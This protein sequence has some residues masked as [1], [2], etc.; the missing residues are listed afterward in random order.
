MISVQGQIMKTV[1]LKISKQCTVVL[2]IM[3][4]HALVDNCPG[5]YTPITNLNTFKC[6]FI[7]GISG[8]DVRK[9]LLD[10][11]GGRMECD[12]D[13]AKNTLL[14]WGTQSDHQAIEK[15][16]QQMQ[17]LAPQKAIDG[18]NRS[19]RII[20]AFYLQQAEQ[21]KNR[22]IQQTSGRIQAP[23]PLP[24]SSQGRNQNQG[25]VL[26]VANNQP[27]Q[28]RSV[29]LRNISATDFERKLIENLGKRF[30][31][32]TPLSSNTETVQYQLP[33]SNGQPLDMIIDRRQ[34]SVI[35]SGPLRSIDAFAHVI[36]LMD[37]DETKP[38]ISTELVPFNPGNTRAV[39]ETIR[40]IGKTSQVA[41]QQDTTRSQGT[42]PQGTQ[43]TI[44]EG[45]PSQST[46]GK[47]PT[48]GFTIPGGAGLVGPV[49][50]EILDDGVVVVRGNENDVKIV[51]EMLQH[52]EAI[53][54]E[55]EPIIHLYQLAHADSSR[56]ATMLR[57]LYTEIYQSR[58]GS[59]SITALVKPN[60]ILLIG[61]EGSIDAALELL[62]KLD[63]AVDAET[64]FQVFRLRF[65][66]ASTLQ[67]TIEG[68]FSDREALGATVTVTS[69][70]RTNALIVQASPRDM[71]EI[72]TLV[73]K[74]DVG[75]SDVED[76]MKVIPLM[77][78]LASELAPIVQQ[79][80]TGRTSTQGFGGATA[81]T[82]E[83]SA[84]LSFQSIDTDANKIIKSD[85]F[86]D[87]RVTA[88]SRGNNI[89]V[90]A[91]GKCMPLIE[92]LVRQLDAAPKAVSQIK[93]FN[94][95]NSDAETLMSMLST[96][97]TTSQTATNQPAVRTGA[98]D[99]ESSLIPVR[100]AVDPRTNSIVA[101]GAEGDLNII[102]A[103]LVR[104]DERD[105]HNRRVMVYRLL[106]TPST[107]VY[108]ALYSYLNNERSLRQSTEVLVGDVDRFKSE[109]VIT[110]EPTTNSLIIS[111]TPRYYEQV[112]RIIKE[113]DERPPM[114]SIAVLIAEVTLSN[115]D[116]LGF[117]LGLQDSI[118]FDRSVLSTVS[119]G[120]TTSSSTSSPGF[121]F[122][123]PSL[124]LGR[125]PTGTSSDKNAATQGITN[126]GLGRTS[127]LGYSGFMF[128][129]SSES[130][131]VL[132]RALEERNKVTILHRPTLTTVHNEEAYLKVGQTVQRIT[133]MSNNDSGGQNT[134]MEDTDVGVVLRIK[135]RVSPDGRI[136]MVIDASKSSLGSSADGVP[137]GIGNDGN[138]IMS[139]NINETLVQTTVSSTSGQTV[140]LGGLINEENTVIQRGV[141]WLSDVPIVGRLFR[142]DYENC[143]RKEILFIMTP[144]ILRSDEEVMA[145]TQL[146]TSRMAWCANHVADMMGDYSV[147]RRTDDW[148]SAETLIERGEVYIPDE[149]EMMSTEQIID[150][151]T[152]DQLP[153]PQFAPPKK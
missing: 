56:V 117:E 136:V 115:T 91:P 103:I 121:N 149:Q 34:N 93:V 114:V 20:S 72:V 46:N 131:S 48:Q 107:D 75:N 79:A 80:I 128:S 65:A 105:L 95:V 122:A 11:F 89:I 111:T 125:H 151:S 58:K 113:L 50:V 81:S 101:S 150:R 54:M 70:T 139:P 130:V 15:R 27:Q 57:Q 45:A 102:E 118:L 5:Q 78:T 38:D 32:V 29:V 31:N 60:A 153:I 138:S 108:N 14:I 61:Y 84:I 129:A 12:V 30:I 77:N 146:E 141:P 37:S 66:S 3:L 106:N 134:T 17:C 99:G 88:D 9:Q 35:V 52:L 13:F 119:G 69:D 87:V 116:E 144:R 64:Q 133:G 110:D 55:H 49:T 1:F 41:H 86:T 25:A 23:L 126:F 96:L 100:F 62:S 4:F 59:I 148:T 67:T 26:P 112:R 51:K 143:Y 92:S 123:D 90:V 137:I 33:I 36:A 73:M 109:V 21:Q 85:I 28:M 94:I 43:I 76:E 83:R 44:H 16:L 39:S 10:E 82:S 98:G 152:I 42:Q 147:K 40:A 74:L 63:I 132:I 6:Y 53:S 142:Y 145:M 2:L 120:G 24:H 18:L 135:P 68:F 124:G 97:F 140:V 71:Q 47:T 19:P 22:N 7:E 104:L 127:E 8:A